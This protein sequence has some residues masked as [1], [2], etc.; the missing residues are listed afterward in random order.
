MNS[1]KS[2]SFLFLVFSMLL[3]TSQVS[4]GVIIFNGPFFKVTVNQDTKTKFSAVVEGW[5]F[6]V[7][8]NMVPICGDID[9]TPHPGENGDGFSEFISYEG[10]WGLVLQIQGFGND[11]FV[12][13]LDELLVDGKEVVVNAALANVLGPH[14][15]PLPGGTGIFIPNW[16]TNGTWI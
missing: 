4:A 9:I 7:C 6:P 11:V 8:V 16:V 15:E 13:D 5:D 10:N 14:G 2:Y 12:P 1:Y 3:Y